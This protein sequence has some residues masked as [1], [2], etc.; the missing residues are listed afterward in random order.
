MWH[1]ESLAPPVQPIRRI[2]VFFSFFSRAELTF[3]RHQD[4]DYQSAS[5][6][7]LSGIQSFGLLQ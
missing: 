2:S 1:R 4:D 3:R 6:I 5:S 7:A